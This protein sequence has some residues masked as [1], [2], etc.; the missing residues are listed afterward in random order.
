MHVHFAIMGLC[1]LAVALDVRPRLG[2]G[3]FGVLFAYAHL[4]DVTN[5]LNHY[6]LI[7]Q[8]S[9]LL[10]VL[11]ATP[12]VP[13]W[14]LH[15]A[16]AQVGLVYV[17]GGLAKLGPDWLLHGEPL[18]TWLAAA[19]DVPIVGPLF[20][21]PHAGLVASWAGAFF[22]LTIVGWLLWPRTRAVAYGVVVVFH[23]I[24]GRLFHLGLFPWLMTA[25]ATIF[26]A[27]SWPRRL[28]F[29]RR[30]AAAIDLPRTRVL[31]AALVAV[32]LG[33]QAVVP[34]RGALYGGNPLWHE[35][36]F[37]FAWNVM[38]IEKSGALDFRVRDADTGR[39]FLVPASDYY[40]RVQA[41]MMATQPD[42][43]LQGA[44]AVADDFRARG[45]RAE[46]YADAFVSL[47]GRARSRLIDPGVDLARERDTLA[48]KPWILPAP[49]SPP[50]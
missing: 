50:P 11:P 4:C 33:I 18:T 16:R 45:V 13:A 17:F 26:F 3:L 37:R 12:T 10:A 14:A 28:G 24:T 41:A 48:G 2:A 15:A 23:L 8:V 1:A 49:N 46:V 19:T 32:H 6:Y 44:H 7:I 25:L 9:F 42:L 43:I 22:D 27:P 39:T 5:Y 34:W 38:L 47:N 36:G 21:L 30:P 35:Q 20:A 40:T 31:L 29:P